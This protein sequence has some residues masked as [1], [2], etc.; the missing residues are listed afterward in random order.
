MRSDCGLFTFTSYVVALDCPQFTSR[1]GEK[2]I[3]DVIDMYSDTKKIKILGI[4]ES[5]GPLVNKGTKGAENAFQCFLDCFLNTQYTN[6]FSNVTILGRITLLNEID[7]PNGDHVKRLDTFVEHIL[8][9]FIQEN[10]IPIIIGGGHNN[11]LPLMR[12]TNKTYPRLPS[13]I[14]N[15]DAHADC[16]STEIRHSGNSFS[17]A[18]IEESIDQ[19]SVLGLHEAYN[20][21]FI[22]QFLKEKK[23]FHSFFESYIFKHRHVEHDIQKCIEDHGSN[24]GIEIDL[25]AIANFPSSANS[26]SG[27]TT[28]EIRCILHTILRFQQKV[29]YVHLTEAGPHNRQ[30]E[31]IVGKTLSYLVRDFVN[32]MENKFP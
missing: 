9:T 27:W 25:D 28:T 32:F 10:E 5:I 11:A 24:L 29:F 4:S 22:L 13:H 30:E 1:N 6:A 15:I 17:T 21:A 2:K 31:K 16:R 23:V 7:S 12:W 3:G 18:L 19:Y 8:S 26:P 14:L 20:N